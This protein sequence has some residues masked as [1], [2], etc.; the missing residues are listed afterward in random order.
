MSAVTVAPP[1]PATSADVD[2]WIV[3]CPVATES[4]RRREAQAGRALRRS[5]MNAPLAIGVTPSFW[6]SVPPV[7]FGD[8]DVRHLG[9]VGRVAAD[10][11]A[12]TS[13]AC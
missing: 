1:R 5:V 3:T 12:A 13:S 7:M 6:N 4:G 11:E 10:H 9:A 2:A 8:L